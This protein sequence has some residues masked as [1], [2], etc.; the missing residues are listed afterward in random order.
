MALFL[1]KFLGNR[2][3]ILYQSIGLDR[4][5]P[6]GELG[7]AFQPVR[8]GTKGGAGDTNSTIIQVRDFMNDR[9][10]AA[11]RRGGRPVQNRFDGVQERPVPVLL[12]NAPETLDRVVLAVVR[13]QVN[14]PVRN[15][16][17]IG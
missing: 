9:R 17:S 13:R 7:A 2:W 6:L 8:N 12:Q 5:A 15:I 16:V 11:P 4:E 14:G 10:R 3:K 1:Y